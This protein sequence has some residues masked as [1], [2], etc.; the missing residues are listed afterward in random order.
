M[1]ISLESYRQ[2]IGCFSQTPYSRS[3]VRNVFIKP[4]RNT[5]NLMLL[6]IRILLP[7]S[8]LILAP[9]SFYS[10]SQ[11]NKSTLNYKLHFNC[12]IDSI[13]HP[14]WKTGIS[15][16]SSNDGNKLSHATNGNKRNMGYKY[17]SWNCGRGFISENKLEDLKMFIGRHEPHAI[18]VSEVDLKRNENNQDEAATNNFSTNQ[19]YEKLS[20]DNYKIVLPKSWD[21]LG[22]ARL[23]VYVH[24]DIKSVQLH[25]QDSCY[26]HLQSITLEMGFGKSKTHLCNFYYREWTNC[27]NGRRDMESQNNELELLLDIWRNCTAHD[28]KDFVALG[29]MNLCALRW[30]EPNYEY[31]DLANKVKDFLSEE[32]CSQLVN[33]FT[34]IR[35]VGGNIQRSCLDHATVNCVGKVSKPIILGVGRSDHLGIIITKAS[36]EVRTYARTTKKRIYKMFDPESF[37]ADIAKAKEDGKF[38]DVVHSSDPDEAFDLFEREF[39]IILDK[40]APLKVIQNRTHYVPY[41]S[42]EIKRNMEER[43]KL[44][45]YATQS[46]TPEDYETYKKKRN[47]VSSLLKTAEREYYNKK[48]DD[49][50]SSKTVWR[51]AFSILGNQRSSFPS[52]IL[53]DGHLLSS[54]KAIA[55]AVNNFFINKISKLKEES[56]RER[57]HHEHPLSELRAYLSKKKIPRLGFRFKELT[58]DDMKELLKQLKGKKSAGIDW[59]CGYSLKIAAPLLKEE[60]KIIINLCFRN[61]KFVSK[62]KCAK[63]LPAWKNKGT[64]FELKFYRPLSNLSEVSK[65]VEKAAFDQMYSYLVTNDLIH[66]NH[67]GFLRNSSTSSALQHALDIWLQHLDKGKLASV[68]FLDL[69]AG[70]D[71]INHPILLDKMKEYA[72]AEETIDWFRSYLKDRSQYVQVESSMSP[73][74]P[75]PWGV[76]QGSILGPLLFLLF[77]NKLPNVVKE[78]LDHNEDRDNDAHSNEVS[79]YDVVVYADDNSPIA[80][81]P[82][83]LALQVKTQH[84]ADVVTKWFSKNDMICSS[85]K[86]KLLIAGTNANRLSKLLKNKCECLWRH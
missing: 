20:I 6:F 19:L 81:D 10:P 70:F 64:R 59:I 84:L 57:N 78:P 18:G 25:P 65:L 68:L 48:L 52:Q 83:P 49:D 66:H 4:R 79:D 60:L 54:P 41:I 11:L 39:G 1:S 40:H 28:G 5:F 15:W 30:D 38:D 47:H 75:V 33:D 53:H 26:D 72:F 77:I 73:T 3:K 8:L 67:H 61:N 37:R 45:E 46:G 16:S 74:L 82:Q 29:D 43:N 17:L 58:D 86:T 22:S 50:A 24:E 36:R 21:T 71:V 69:S 51:A 80:A 23:V 63:V 9:D 34:R 7:L 85:E 13:L 2:R 32:D 42:P 31:K 14:L 62:W 76:P 35:S 56:T 44:K 27:L 55:A 12:E